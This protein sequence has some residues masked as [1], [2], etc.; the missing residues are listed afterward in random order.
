M[1][2][3]MEI[4]YEKIQCHMRLLSDGIGGSF[5]MKQVTSILFHIFKKGIINYVV[6]DAKTLRITNAMHA[7]SHLNE[8]LKK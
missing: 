7:D 1:A 8:L 4:T 5:S 3:I 2:Y 6:P